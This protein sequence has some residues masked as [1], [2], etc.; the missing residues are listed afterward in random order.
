MNK[1]N[2]LPIRQALFALIAACALSACTTE[3]DLLGLNL[4]PQ[5]DRLNALYNDTTTVLAFNTSTD[6]LRTSVLPG[7]SG[8][9]F[10][11]ILCGAIYDSTFG[12]IEA[13]FA[14]Q[15]WLSTLKPVFTNIPVADSVVFQVPYAGL[16]GDTLSAQ[17]LKVYEL[18]ESLRS[19]TTYYSN[20]FITPDP[21]FLLATSTFVPKIK[22]SVTVDA[23]KYP[24]LLRIKLANSFGNK[25]LSGGANLDNQENFRKYIKGFYVTATPKDVLGQGSILTLDLS[26]S[27]SG[28][29]VYY[30][31]PTDSGSLSVYVDGQSSQRFN[32]FNT[33]NYQFADPLFKAQYLSKDTTKGQ[34]KL[35]LSGMSPSDIKITFPYILKYNAKQKTGFNQA[36]LVI[37]APYASSTIYPPSQLSLYKVYTDGK[38][39]AV[40]DQSTSTAAAVNGTYDTTKKQYRFAITQYLQN[41]LKTGKQDYYLVLSTNTPGRTP[42]E[43]VIPGTKSGKNR[44]RLEMIYTTQK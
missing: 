17:T 39:Y 41:I 13:S 2:L 28:I 37:D 33:H 9:S 44:I 36:F 35:F 27:Y 1:L 38:K 3:P 23:I 32:T 11:T 6:T 30:H 29:K 4:T 12:K 19:D 10:N 21:A 18:T 43:L 31:T 15:L 14:S 16:F 24:P 42:A 8:T 22:D 34:Q 40:E 7:Y 5:G 25:I 20:H 26:G